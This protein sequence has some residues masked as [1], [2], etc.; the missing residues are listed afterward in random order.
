MHRIVRVIFLCVILAF[1]CST[2]SESQSFS[3]CAN[4]GFGYRLMVAPAGS[5]DSYSTYFDKKKSGSN[6][7]FDFLW[8][9]D[10]YALGIGYNRF[11]NSVSGKNVQLALFNKVDVREKIRVDYYNIQFHRIKQVSKTRFSMDFEVGLGLVKYYND[12]TAYSE[13]IKIEGKTLAFTVL[14]LLI[15]K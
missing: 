7:T 1:V 4:G 13:V 11:F 9:Q 3:F 14:Y 12:S 5:Y 6:L 2:K 15:T 8:I 10:V